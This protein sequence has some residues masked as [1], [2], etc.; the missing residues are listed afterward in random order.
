MNNKPVAVTR[1]NVIEKKV[2]SRGIGCF[3]VRSQ[4]SAVRSR[5]KQRYLTVHRWGVN[6]DHRQPVGESS[7]GLAF[8]DV[9][10]NKST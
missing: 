10:D 3:K 4:I 1:L 5:A 7:K 9:Y 6:C 2:V 8:H